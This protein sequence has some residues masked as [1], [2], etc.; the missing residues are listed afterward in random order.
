[1]A[2]VLSIAS[3]KKGSQFMVSAFEM[4]C[5]NKTAKHT[6]E[7]L[8]RLEEF[9]YEFSCFGSADD[10]DRDHADVHVDVYPPWLVVDSSLFA[11][12]LLFSK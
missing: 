7:K 3:D 6:K 10:H 9:F 5:K 12:H 11:T 8:L 4:R 2:A 1:M